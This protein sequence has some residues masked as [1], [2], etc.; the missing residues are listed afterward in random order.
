MIEDNKE[1]TKKA[2]NAIA[3]QYFEVYNDD[4]EDLIY[5]DNF[6]KG[7]NS[8]ILDLGC[9]MGHYSRYMENKGFEVCGVDFSKNMLELARKNNKNIKFFESDI[10][11][12][13]N[14]LD[15]DFDGVLLAYVIQHLTVEET[16][17]VL[18][19]LHNYIT[20]D[21]KLLI[22]FRE[23]DGIVKEKEPFNPTFEYEIKQYNKYE[24]TN[25]L[26]ECGYEVTSIEDKPI[27][28]D[29]YSLCPTTVV[30]Y[31]E[32]KIKKMM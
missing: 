27:V 4:T 9:G 15:K 29:E 3:R 28:Y 13:P 22:F 10:C 11:N 21:C 6:L 30:L 17:Q 16:K 24:L 26:N 12:L 5:I 7:C 18:L 2:H 25:L 32:N 31:A 20:V 14:E 8:K 19:N 23:G 1:I